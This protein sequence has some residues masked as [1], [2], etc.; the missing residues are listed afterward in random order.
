[1]SHVVLIVEDDP[2]LVELLSRIIEEEGDRAVVHS[3]VASG[4]E[5]ALALGYD[6]MILDWML[7]DGDGAALC[8][9][10]RD[11]GVKKPILMLTARGET[12]DRVKGLKSGADDYLVKPFDVEEL[13]L[14]LQGLLRR[15]GDSASLQVGEL[16][17][18]RLARTAIIA[19]RKLELTAKELDVL[20]AL[21]SHP[22]EIQSR[23]T[24]LQVV[25]QLTS[26]PGSGVLDVHVSRL[27]DKLGKHAWM[28]ETIRGSGLRLRSAP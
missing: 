10:L 21:A 28:I 8:R 3:S 17:V 14:R 26:D 1:M 22:G 27:R 5:A 13:L 15:S 6:V 9:E 19:G 7:P 20:I 12:P 18:D 4:R 2:Q 23:A 25:W 11:K 16:A 24:L